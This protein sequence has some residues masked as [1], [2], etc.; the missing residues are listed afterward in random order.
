M[1]RLSQS[2]TRAHGIDAF[3]CHDSTHKV[4]PLLSGQEVERALISLGALSSAFCSVPLNPRAVSYK[5]PK[6]NIHTFLGKLE[7]A[8]WAV[9]FVIPVSDKISRH[10]H[11]CAR[12]AAILRASTST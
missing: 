4:G 8:R 10:K 11:P 1:A 3:D 2:S 12:R 7:S 9:P 5:S 6:A